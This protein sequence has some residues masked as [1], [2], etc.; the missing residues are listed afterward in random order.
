VPIADDVHD[1]V[2]REVSTHVPDA[3]VSDTKGRVGYEIPFTQVFYRYTPPRA[4]E[5]IRA[6]LQELEGEVRRLLEEI[7]V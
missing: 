3:I 4:S 5:E 7:L 6:D 1:F 2:A